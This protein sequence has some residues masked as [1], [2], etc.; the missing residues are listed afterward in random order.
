[1]KMTKRLLSVA[2]VNELLVL[3]QALAAALLQWH[4]HNST[5]LVGVVVQEV[6]V[7]Y[8]VVPLYDSWPC[9]Y[10]SISTFPLRSGN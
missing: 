7:D 4:K 2:V 5:V 3:A 6:C 10:R 8:D 9:L 1:M